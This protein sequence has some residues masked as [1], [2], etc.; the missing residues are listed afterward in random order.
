MAANKTNLDRLRKN[1]GSDSEAWP[2]VLECRLLGADPFRMAAH[3][4]GVYGDSSRLCQDIGLF[5]S[6]QSSGLTSHLCA[7]LPREG[8]PIAEEMIRFVPAS[9]LVGIDWRPTD[10]IGVSRE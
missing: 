7:G 10:D 3:T 8:D 1:E 5:S 6:S 4:N 2:I 9:R